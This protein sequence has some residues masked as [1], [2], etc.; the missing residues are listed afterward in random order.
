ME[1]LQEGFW[2]LLI[3][4]PNAMGS[5]P[6]V[7]PVTAARYLIATST[8]KSDGT[9]LLGDADAMRA[10]AARLSDIATRAMFGIAPAAWLDLPDVAALAAWSA[11]GGDRAGPDARAHAVRD[12]ACTATAPSS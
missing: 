8:R 7:T 12:A 9:D 10:L 11:Q 6:Q 1:S 4:W 3:G 2:H 5:D